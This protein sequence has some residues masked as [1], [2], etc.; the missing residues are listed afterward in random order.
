LDNKNLPGSCIM[1]LLA[2]LL[3][4]CLLGIIWPHPFIIAPFVIAHPLNSLHPFGIA[5]PYVKIAMLKQSS[6]MGWVRGPYVA[7]KIVE[8]LAV[9]HTILNN[10]PSTVP[11]PLPLPLPL[12]LLP[13][14]LH[15]A[16]RL[17]SS[18]ANTASLSIFR[19]NAPPASWADTPTF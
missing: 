13:W 6:S 4:S 16:H 11:F 17:S 1:Y 15:T 19:G 5:L 8:Y 2:R 7:L 3:C 12:P 10:S 14:A 9:L 18:N